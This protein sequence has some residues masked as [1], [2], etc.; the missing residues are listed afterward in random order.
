MALFKARLQNA[1]RYKYKYKRIAILGKE[2]CY[3]PQ[4][5]NCVGGNR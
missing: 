3:Y 5:G 4:K 2:R 1:K